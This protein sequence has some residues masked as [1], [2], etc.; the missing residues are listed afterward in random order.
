[1]AT[2]R[3][4]QEILRDITAIEQLERGKLC[5]MRSKSGRVYYNLQFWSHGRN[6]CEYVRGQD[7]AAVQE[8]VAN[9]DRF[10]ELMEEY[11]ATM[12]ERTRAA[13]RNREEAKK[14]SATR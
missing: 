12:E 2:Q 10:R 6:R 5:K 13:R 7:L 4:P 9:G 8:A 3:A 11:A 14:N 1:M